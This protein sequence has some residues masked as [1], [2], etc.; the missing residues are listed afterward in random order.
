VT[1]EHF[2][3]ALEEELRRC[4]VQFTHVD[5]HSFVNVHW[6][7]IAKDPDVARWAREF[8]D[9]GQGSVTV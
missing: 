8:L 5:V 6:P 1:H 9:S 3:E 2:I 4:R 7:A